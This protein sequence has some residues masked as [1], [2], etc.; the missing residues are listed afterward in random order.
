VSYEGVVG[1]V[2]GD[3]ADEELGGPVLSGLAQLG[4]KK[5]EIDG[6]P[7]ILRTRNGDFPIVGPL[8]SSPSYFAVLGENSSEGE[9]QST[10]PIESFEDRV[11]P[12]GG[13]ES[14][15]LCSNG[16]QRVQLRENKKASVRNNLNNL[17]F[18]ML[19]KLPGGLQGAR[20]KKKHK[21]QGG[22]IRGER[23]DD[24]SDSG[25][26]DI[27]SSD[28]LASHSNREI[29]LEVVLPFIGEVGSVPLATERGTSGM[30][31]LVEGVGFIVDDYQSA[32]SY[33]SDE[34]VPMAREIYEAKKLIAINEDLGLKFHDGTGADVERMMAMEVR[35]RAEKKVREQSRGYQ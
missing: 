1:H 14:K 13:V 29:Q 31:H 32:M 19:R 21:K 22:R 8:V 25:T 16:T 3:M 23:C 27:Q 7:Q 9:E 18:S 17:P 20:R 30:E 12:G 26:D 28:V 2:V 6:G 5:C 35:D 24:G 4:E 33:D 10:D 15:S 34:G 11:L